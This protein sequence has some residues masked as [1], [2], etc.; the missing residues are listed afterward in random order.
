MTIA[1]GDVYTTSKMVAV[2]FDYPADATKWEMFLGVKDC[3]TATITN[4]IPAPGPST[5]TVSSF[6]VQA[7]GSGDG[8]KLVTVCLRDDA[9]LQTGATDTIVLDRAVPFGSFA[10]NSGDSV[11][12]DSLLSLEL[13]PAADV[14]AYAISAT[15]DPDVI[16]PS[17]NAAE[18]SYSDYTTTLVN[19]SLP[20]LSAFYRVEVCFK[21]AAGLYFKSLGSIILDVDAPSVDGVELK[22][23]GTNSTTYSQQTTVLVSL[24]ISDLPDFSSGNSDDQGGGGGTGDGPGGGLGSTTSGEDNSTYL[25]MI[26]SEDS[27]FGDTDWEGFKQNFT[28]TLSETNGDKTVYVKI[29]DSAGWE[30]TTGSDS[31]VLDT[32]SPEVNAVAF[33][34]VGDGIPGFINPDGLVTG[35]ANCPA[36]SPANEGEPK[37]FATLELDAEDN[38]E[39]GMT[40]SAKINST[41]CSS[42][43]APLNAGTAQ[44][45]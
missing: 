35:Q 6:D 23:L 14:A 30:S 42:D 3:D 8:E 20:E 28:F 29:R 40:V 10:I 11:T 25:E 2:A 21:D 15:S 41:S 7:D 39:N 26:V 12:S 31:I 34:A 19:Y 44:V 37:R 27:A 24:T 4:S 13:E 18:L 43:Y 5:H 9:G 1:G 33:T 38:L 45:D 32:E 16:L 17:C 22:A 36:G